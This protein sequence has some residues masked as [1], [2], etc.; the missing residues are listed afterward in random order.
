[1]RWRLRVVGAL[2]LLLLLVALASLV[3]A[4]DDGDQPKRLAS[5]ARAH[6]GARG[7]PASID[8]I[9]AV[10][11]ANGITAD[12]NEWSCADSLESGPSAVTNAGYNGLQSRD[13]VEA[14]EGS[15]LCTVYARSYG[16]VVDTTK[17]ATDW[18]TITGVL[19][20]QC[21]IYPSEEASRRPQVRRLERALEA[22][23]RA[24]PR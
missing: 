5:E 12:L 18:E 2:L 8:R 17:Y 21:S 19:N 23:V 3:D 24:T 4:F 15:V 14:V 9:V 7:A 16:R 6:C 11:R 1:M 20:I 22:L 13:E 10:F